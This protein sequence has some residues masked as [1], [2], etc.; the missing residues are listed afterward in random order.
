MERLD[1][2]VSPHVMTETNC[3]MI[4]VS[5]IVQTNSSLMHFEMPF[6]ALRRQTEWED[7]WVIC[8]GLDCCFYLKPISGI[9]LLVVFLGSY[10]AS[11]YTLLSWILTSVFKLYDAKTLSIGYISAMND[12]GTWLSN[13]N[14]QRS[15][16]R[17]VLLWFFYLHFEIGHS[18]HP[19]NHFSRLLV[20]KLNCYK[21]ML[22]KW[23]TV[24]PIKG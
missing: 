15:H 19:L 21:T 12:D 23:T 5:F 8:Y 18:L 9:F 14:I 22:I 16:N 10:K 2:Y 13:I 6:Q 17:D 7:W 3:C 11:E 20:Y 24:L 1:R 4:L